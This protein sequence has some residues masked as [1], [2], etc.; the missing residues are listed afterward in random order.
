MRWSKLRNPHVSIV[1]ARKLWGERAESE[2]ELGTSGPV[3]VNA[4]AG[5]RGSRLAD[6][7][8]EKRK[9]K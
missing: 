1:L 8:L 9:G 3:E 4:S 6:P 2:L 7:K 5:A